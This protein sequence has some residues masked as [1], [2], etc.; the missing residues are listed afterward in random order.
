MHVVPRRTRLMPTKLVTAAV[1][2][3]TGD[4]IA[5]LSGAS[6]PFA[7]KRLLTLV[8]VNIF[9]IVPILSAF[10]ALNEVLARYLKLEDDVRAGRL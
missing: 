10:Y 5:Q 6:A 1:L 3:G 7:I 9:Y 2:S 4:V 8:A